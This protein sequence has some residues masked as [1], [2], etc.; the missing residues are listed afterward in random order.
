MLGRL[1]AVTVVVE[2]S[3][4]LM[5]SILVLFVGALLTRKFSLLE[6]YSIP[7]AVTGGILCSGIVALL[8]KFADIQ[9]TF[10]NRLRDLLLLIFFSTIGLS[11]KFRDLAAGGRALIVLVAVAT[12]FLA[13]QDLTGVLLAKALGVHPAY[14]LFGGSVSLAGG[15]GT[16]IAW[17][18]VAVEAGLTYARETGIAFATV[19]LIAGGILGGPVGEWLVRRHRLEPVDTAEPGDAADGATNAQQESWRVKDTLGTIF[20]LAVCVELGDLVNQLLFAN[21]VVLPGFL[22]AMGIGIVITNTADLAGRPLST[23]AIDRLGQLA[24]PLFLSMSL[25]GMQLWVLGGAV[26]KILLVL[27]IQVLVM[28]AF[29]VAVIFRAMGR[30]YDAAVI[31]SG[32][33]GLGLGATPV[34]IANM[35]ALTSKYAPS[36]KAFLVIPLVGAFFIDIANAAVIKFFVALPIIS[37]MNP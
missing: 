5:I 21:G 17:G 1:A 11:A 7:P 22:T 4:V 16:A 15:F 12:G 10:D 34:G 9:I 26:G 23:A 25:M 14:G 29:A 24:L 37:G 20:V 32:F 36:P 6:R 30:D 28:T 8:Y 27:T 33:V 13:I 31:A 3:H 35:E 19:G 18:D 2:G